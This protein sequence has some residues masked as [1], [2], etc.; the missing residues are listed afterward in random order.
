LCIGGVVVVVVVVGTC[1]LLLLWLVLWGIGSCRCGEI[2][3]S[4]DLT[5]RRTDPANNNNNATNAQ[6]TTTTAAATTTT[7]TITTNPGTWTG[8]AQYG[9]DESIPT[10]GDRPIP[11]PPA[12]NTYLATL[13]VHDLIERVKAVLI[14]DNLKQKDLASY[15]GISGS[16]L[17]PLLKH[18]YM[19]T[20]IQ[21]LQTLIEWLL[22]RDREF[23][24]MINS[25]LRLLGM[26]AKTIAAKLNLTLDQWTNWLALKD[27]HADRSA[28]DAEIRHLIVALT[29]TRMG[30]GGNDDDDDDDSRQPHLSHNGSHHSNGD[31]A[32]N[33]NNGGGGDLEH[34]DDDML[35]NA[36]SKS[37]LVQNAFP[38]LPR[39][40]LRSV[41]RII[42][43][44]STRKYT[45]GDEIDD[46]IAAA[47]TTTTTGDGD[48]NE[49][50]SSSG[51]WV[52][53]GDDYG[54]GGNSISGKDGGTGASHTH[55]WP[56][57]CDA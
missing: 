6:T 51:S 37:L 30:G 27:I 54:Q 43:D 23:V 36:Q 17:S 1:V 2:C 21:H 24:S 5:T 22:T 57:P 44:L 53:D 19:H 10:N 31:Y 38:S 11:Y 28:V 20:K 9:A 16:T 45:G 40:M 7:T 49:G 15:V 39:N 55:C 25:R 13:P 56:G 46:M 34:N 12:A 41:V 29:Q 8:P 33:N 32:N 48:D 35:N 3:S 50:S 42:G 52:G 4:G 26:D 47:A 14:R 18:K